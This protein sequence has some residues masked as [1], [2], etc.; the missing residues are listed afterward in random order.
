MSPAPPGRQSVAAEG[1]QLALRFPLSSRCRFDEFVVGDNAELVR[2]LEELP[3]SGS[4][5]AGCFLSGSTGAGRTHLLQAACHRHGG[6]GGAIYL[7]LADAAVVPELLDGLERLALVALDDVQHWSGDERREAALLALYQGLLAAGGWLLVSADVP[8]AQL[9][10]RYADLASRLRGL[11]AYQVRE[12]DDAGKALV[13]ARVA[14]ERGLDLRSAVLE[15]WFA[16]GSRNLGDLLDQL[17]RLDA[18]AMAAQRRI[19]VPLVKEVLG[20]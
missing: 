12:P 13:L 20:L 4:G 16:R 17:D 5:I 7:P 8:A 2:R 9:R 14:R 11:P 19:T 18:A 15:F 10:F 1:G 6:Q 3:R